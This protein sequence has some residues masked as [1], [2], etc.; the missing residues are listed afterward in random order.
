[1]NDEKISGIM[2]DLIKSLEANDVE[3]T[4]SFFTDDG[5]WVNP[6]GTF[7]GK[8]E[9]RR[10]MTAEAQTMKDVKIT[11]TGNK[12]MV[13][14]DRAF[15]EHDIAATIEG[16]RVEGLAMCAYEFSGDKIREV[17]TVYDR[18][19]MAKQAAKGWLPKKLVNSII[20][21]AEKGL[22]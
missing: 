17:R 3:K 1:M 4:L 8:A 12:I 6:N 16:K 9:L 10:Y 20:K 11:E 7:K 18:L 5:V 21:Q 13:Q 2:R 22:R 19:L 15:Y 14:G